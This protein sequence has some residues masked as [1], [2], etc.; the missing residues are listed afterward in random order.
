MRSDR[1]PLS[2]G[3]RRDPVRSIEGHVGHKRI[4]WHDIWSIYVTYSL[5]Y[6][7]IYGCRTTADV[8]SAYIPPYNTNNYLYN[9]FSFDKNPIL[10][11][12][13]TVTA[14]SL[15]NIIYLLSQL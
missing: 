2:S 14:T 9:R 4:S 13:N 11:S 3:W 15:A 5:G 12:R 8:Y 10:I 7:R 1:A 6:E